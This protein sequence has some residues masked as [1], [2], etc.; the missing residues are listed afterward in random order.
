MSP[1]QNLIASIERY[2]PS[3][4]L[5]TEHKNA[6][7]ALLRE[8]EHC[9]LRSDFPGHMVGGVWLLSPDETQVLMTHHKFL[10]RWFQFG[11]HAD[12]ECDIAN[13]ALREGQEE[14]GIEDIY[15]ISNDIFDIDVHAIPENQ[16]KGEPAH[17]HYELRYLG[18][19][20]TMDFTLSD[21][22]HALRWFT[23]EEAETMST[24]ESRRRMIAKWK[25]RL[26]R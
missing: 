11:G 7:L 2:A 5:E 15:L 1:H 19:A 25:A 24:D 9:F 10:D 13:V 22:S 4:A 8:T 20:R 21:E 18:K 3:D 16:K 17:W 14:S 12:G 26:A 23:M 6:T